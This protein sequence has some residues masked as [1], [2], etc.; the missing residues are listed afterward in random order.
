M[1]ISDGD[2]GDKWITPV[3]ISFRYRENMPL[4]TAI[5]K[6]RGCELRF[7]FY[8]LRIPDDDVL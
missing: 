1:S 3:L 4:K 2:F 6:Q 5:Y 7:G 8:Y